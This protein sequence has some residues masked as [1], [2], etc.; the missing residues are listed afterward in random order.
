MILFQRVLAGNSRQKIAERAL[1][2][3]INLY[4]CGMSKM[5]FLQERLGRY[6][7]KWRTKKTK[8]KLRLS[9]FETAQSI[10]I[11]YS[12]TEKLHSQ[13]I[14]KFAQS[15]AQSHANTQISIIEYCKTDNSKQLHKTNDFSSTTIT[16]NDFTWYGTARNKTLE[17]FIQ[18]PFDILIDLNFEP[19]F[20]IEYIVELSQANFKIG[21]LNQSLIYDFMIDIKNEKNIDY[22]IQQ[23][24]V[25]LPSLKQ[26]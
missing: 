19:I 4:F 22:L 2:C 5:N 21:Q 10:A 24:S 3:T 9:T 26:K 7:L 23:I 12:N 15:I 1:P 14:K 8:R 17:K 11:I 20:A 25:Y 13:N 18:T 6:F 16:K